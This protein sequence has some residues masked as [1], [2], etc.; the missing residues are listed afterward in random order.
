MVA[1]SVI[2]TCSICTHKLLRCTAV[3]AC[4][5]HSVVM[6]YS[7]YQNKNRRMRP[8]RLMP[9]LHL[10]GSHTTNRSAAAT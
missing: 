9:P 8:V 6:C 7:G 5:A 3:A 10:Q 1:A 4:D 2:M